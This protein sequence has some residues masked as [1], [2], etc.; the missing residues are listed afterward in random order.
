[1][2]RMVIIAACATII[3]PFAA[4]PA[5]AGE[6]AY[7]PASDLILHGSV[8]VTHWRQRQPVTGSGPAH[9]Y[10]YHPHHV[11]GYP[12]RLTGYPV[13]IYKA[14]SHLHRRVMRVPVVRSGSHAAWCA[15]RYK[16]YD[17]RTDTWQPFHGPRRYCRSPFR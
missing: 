16:S 15:A 3:M 4:V 5:N 14:P 7:D 11:P 9:Y 8:P 10:S 12:R 13:P 17:I 6:W 2:W 1:M